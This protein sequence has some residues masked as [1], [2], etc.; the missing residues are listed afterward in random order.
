MAERSA[1][2]FCAVRFGNVIGSRGSVV[3]IFTRQIQRGG[4][5][6]VTDPEATRYFLLPEAEAVIEDRFDY[7]YGNPRKAAEDICPL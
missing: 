4:P 1:T 6:G 7:G 3:P 2:V 5:V